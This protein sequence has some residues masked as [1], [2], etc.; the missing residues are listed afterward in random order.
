MPNHVDC[1]FTIKGPEDA[2]KLIKELITSNYSVVDFGVEDIEENETK[3]VFSFISARKPP[4]FKQLERR[5]SEEILEGINLRCAWSEPGMLGYGY[6]LYCKNYI[7]TQR[8]FEATF[9]EDENEDS[10]PNGEYLKF[11]EYER[12]PH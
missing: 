12:I 1:V 8:W 7:K 9:V 6:W 3:S 4:S 10:F 5:L 11:L 2:R